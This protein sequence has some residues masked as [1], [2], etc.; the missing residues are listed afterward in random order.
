MAAMRLDQQLEFILEIDKLKSVIRQ[1]LLLDGSRLENSSEHSWHLAVMAPLLLEYAAEPVDCHRVLKMLLIHDVVEVDAGDTYA[2]DDAGNTTKAR[3]EKAAA[4][5]LFGLLPCDQ[6]QEFRQLWD[7]FEAMQ[8]P[9]SRYANAIDRIQ[10]FLLN[11]HSGGRMWREHRIT[12]E[13]VLK[14]MSPVQDGAP[15]LWKIVEQ[16]LERA[17]EKGYLT[18]SR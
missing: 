13:Q 14:R 10:P 4:E 5:R 15:E 8:T 17:I 7:E 11:F 2:Y 16:L 9:E 18:S 6:R 1:T 3:R 12:A